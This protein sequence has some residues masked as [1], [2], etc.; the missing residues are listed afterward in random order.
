M[1]NMY[2][3]VFP[4]QY[5]NVFIR[6]AQILLNYI[7]A[8]NEYDPGNQNIRKYWDMIRSRAGVPSAFIATPQIA[9]N[10]EAQRDYIIRERQIELCFEGDRYF[11]TRRRWLADTPDDGAAK[12]RK[13][14]DG[15]RMFGMDINAGD[16]NTNSFAF[17]DFYKRVPFETRVF[18]KAYYLFP[19]PE[20]EIEKSKALVQNPWW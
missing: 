3:R 10:K 12:D 11:T 9:G 18:K 6:Y 4:Q 14:G 19:I 2:D 16:A 15:G 8:L 17:T 5:G 7:E 20:T 13:F 1:A